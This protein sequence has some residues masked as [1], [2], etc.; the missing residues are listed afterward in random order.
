MLVDVLDDTVVVDYSAVREYKSVIPGVDV[1][2]APGTP[3]N[4]F[5]RGYL[6]AFQ[7][8]CAFL[9]VIFAN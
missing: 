7:T 6:L 8:A 5:A 4:D 1:V 2:A 9:D 3:A